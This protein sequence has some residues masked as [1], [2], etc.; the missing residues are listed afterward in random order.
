MYHMIHKI[1]IIPIIQ[2][3]Y[4]S[5]V[6]TFPLSDKCF[7]FFYIFIHNLNLHIFFKL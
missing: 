4:E 7:D 6:Y 2:L 5:N 1:H 3:V